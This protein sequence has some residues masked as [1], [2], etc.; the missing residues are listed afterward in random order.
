MGFGS[1]CK[2]TDLCVVRRAMDLGEEFLARSAGC[3]GGLACKLSLEELETMDHICVFTRDRCGIPA[4]ASCD[5]RR[6]FRQ[7]RTASRTGGWSLDAEQ[8]SK[9]NNGNLFDSLVT[10]TCW[11]QRNARVFWEPWQAIQRGQSD[12]VE[13][14]KLYRSWSWRLCARVVCCVCAC[15]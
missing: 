3:T 14:M 11:K 8:G 5:S 10:L 13:D 4:P 7:S 9:R 6:S 2:M 12:I 15:V 1:A